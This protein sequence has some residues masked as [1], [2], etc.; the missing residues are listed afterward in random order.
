M[1]KSVCKSARGVCVQ[2]GQRHVR[3]VGKILELGRSIEEAA[4]PD[5][6]LSSFLLSVQPAHIN[7]GRER[8]GG[9]VYMFVVQPSHKVAAHCRR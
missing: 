7:V 6:C 5:E 8:E 3:V 1:G 2:E 4:C 9:R